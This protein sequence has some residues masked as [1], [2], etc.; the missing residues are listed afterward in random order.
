M[1]WL[2]L[3]LLAGCAST[4]TPAEG[5]LDGAYHGHVGGPCFATYVFTGN[6][7][8]LELSCGNEGVA[9]VEHGTYTVDG[10]VV[11]LEPTGNACDLLDGYAVGLEPSTGLYILDP[12]D[13]EREPVNAESD[14][15]FDDFV[16]AMREL[17]L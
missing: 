13:G 8:L 10:D 11:E 14:C 12:L 15:E 2:A 16:V 3:L 7:Y 17:R 5:P 9:R 4:T 1:R 6:R